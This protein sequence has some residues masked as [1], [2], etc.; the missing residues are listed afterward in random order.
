MKEFVTIFIPVKNAENTIKDCIESV[1]NQSYKNIIVWVI[2]NISSDKT[3][4]ILKKYKNR[5]NLCRMSGT[6]PKLHNYVLRKTRTKFIA[7]TNADCVVDKDWL[8]NLLS[9][10]TS[11]DIVATAGYCA[12]PEGLSKFQELIGRELENRFKKFPKFISRAPDMNLCV[13]TDVAKKVKFD[14]RFFWSWETDFGYRLTKLGKM[15]YVPQAVVYHYH[16]PNY[17][18]FVRQQMKNASIIPL[19]YWK[20]FD[21][22]RGD[23]ISTG[24]M[25]LTVLSLYL[26]IFFLSISPFFPIFF[27][28][29]AI[30]FLLFNLLIIKEIFSLSKN[31]EEMQI[32][33]RIFYLRTLAWFVGIPL[34]FYLFIKNK[35]YKDRV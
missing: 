31:I 17:K 9:G 7:Y 32:L 1:L 19:L 30:F 2:D 20:H 4:E 27:I 12:T 5:I 25:A 11:E 29:S 14:E 26:F 34:G 10:F 3:Y 16:R 15:K 8:K 18:S 35:W 6:V 21:K 22:I 23:H 13:R 28:F 33:V 24:N